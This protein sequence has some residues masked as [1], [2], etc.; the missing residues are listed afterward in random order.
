MSASGQS[1]GETGMM[2]SEPSVWHGHRWSSSTSQ[3]RSRAAS[4]R[5]EEKASLGV[6]L[7]WQ[8]LRVPTRLRAFERLDLVWNCMLHPGTRYGQCLQADQIIKMVVDTVD[9][10]VMAVM[11]VLTARSTHTRNANRGRNSVSHELPPRRFLLFAWPVPRL[12]WVA[13]WGVRTLAIPGDEANMAALPIPEIPAL[14]TGAADWEATG[15]S[16]AEMAPSEM[17]NRR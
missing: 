13:A 11:A 5:L 9:W 6:C 7:H 2:R 17:L 14:R 3:W 1:R 16:M 12:L 8:E 10:A 15:L 4:G